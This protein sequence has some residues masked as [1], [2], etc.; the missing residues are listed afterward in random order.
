VTGIGTL[1]ERYK[2]H[3]GTYEWRISPNEA[4]DF[5]T[6]ILPYLYG[7]QQEAL[8]AIEYQSKQGT[9]NH[10]GRGYIVPDNLVQEKEAYY[11]K[12]QELKGTSSKGRGRP[13]LQH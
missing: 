10:K 4:L 5:L 1:H 11:L 12:L 7:K 8:I 3:P 9:K 13:K 6:E 2:Y